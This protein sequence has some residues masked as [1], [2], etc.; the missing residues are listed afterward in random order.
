MVVSLSLNNRIARVGVLLA[1]VGLAALLVVIVL[2]NF[3]IGTMIDYR[4]RFSRDELASPV[5]HFP[6][7]ARLHARLAEAELTDRQRDLASAESHA[8]TAIRLSPYDYRNPLIL[9]SIKE[10]SGDRQ[11]AEEQLQKALAL[12]PNNISVR[13]QLANLL[14]RQ[15]RVDESIEEFR[16]AVAADSRLLAGTIDLIWQVSNKDV[17]MIERVTGDNPKAQ[18]TLAQFLLKQSRTEDAARVFVRIDRR[19]RL[20][21]VETP[22]FLKAFIEAGYP[23][24]ARYLWVG[25]ASSNAETEAPLVWNGGFETDILKNLGQFDWTIPEWAVSKNTNRETRYAR[26]GI[27]RTTAHTGA[28]SLKIEFAGENT[29]RLDGEIK[30]LIALKPG[31]RYRL[32]CYVKSEGLITPEGPRVVVIGGESASEPSKEPASEPVRAGSND[33]QRLTIDFIAPQGK[34]AGQSSVQIA[35]KRIPQFSYDEPTRGTVW[36]DDFK[37]EEHGQGSGVGGQGSGIRD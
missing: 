18:M 7:K 19:A 37:I 23:G 10:A 17:N 25:L 24:L 26:L 35:I 9:A 15:G 13:Y 29:T 3:V 16:K 2:F 5:Y 32:E 4:K 30:Q 27:D 1:A 6:S 31:A 8:L 12:A 22:A 28:R 20:S 21:S 14:V 33:W 34:T 11:A 36:F